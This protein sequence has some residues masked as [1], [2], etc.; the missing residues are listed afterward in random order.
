MTLSITNRAAAPTPPSKS[1]AAEDAQLTKAAQGFEAY[2]LRQMI[3]SMR[4][5]SIGD[6][7]FSSA[8][9]EQYK[10]MHDTQL[11]QSLSEKG[12]FGFA[13]YIEDQMGGRAPI[14]EAKSDG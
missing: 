2:F 7:I 6:D 5:S 14:V 3:H 11:A 12:G 1:P 10:D 4:Q 8:S 9:S 13:H